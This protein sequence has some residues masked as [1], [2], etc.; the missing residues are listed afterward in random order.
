MVLMCT[1][2]VL[3]SESHCVRIALVSFWTCSCYMFNILLLSYSCSR[4]VSVM[5]ESWFRLAS[6]ML[7]LCLPRVFVLYSY[8][9]GNAL[10]L[11]CSDFVFHS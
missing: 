6:V 2:I 3:S 7:L 11:R 8:C 1:C 9:N 4:I 10:V 5:Y